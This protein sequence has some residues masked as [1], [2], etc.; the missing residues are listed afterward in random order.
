MPVMISIVFWIKWIVTA[1]MRIGMHRIVQGL[2]VHIHLEGTSTRGN[3]IVFLNSRILHG[4]HGGIM[5]YAS[6]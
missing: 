3:C 6:L 2:T 1:R 4:T 5:S